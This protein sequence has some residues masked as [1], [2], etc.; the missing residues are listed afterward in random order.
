MDDVIERYISNNDGFTTKNFAEMLR[1]N[2]PDIGRATIYKILKNLC[3]NGRIMRT[4][5]GLFTNSIKSN[6]SY[7]PSVDIL[8]VTADIRREYPLVDY[9]VWELYQLNEFVN[10]QITK[11]T[12]FIEVESMLNESVFN[13]LFSK[14]PHVLLNPTTDEYYKY[15]GNMTII[16]RKLISD[17]PPPIGINSQACLEKIIVDLFEHGLSGNLI[18]KAEYPEIIE[19]AFTRYNINRSKLFRYARRRGL[20]KAIRQF[21]DEKTN[22]DLEVCR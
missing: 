12:L 22:I 19:S 11:N 8:S 1:R 21:I 15:M 10:H 9:Q 7:E 3:E 16:V 14:Y 5:R 4:G 20:E 6:Y 2:N 13:L 17:A 18:E